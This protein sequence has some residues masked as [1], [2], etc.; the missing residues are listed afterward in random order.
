MM[1]ISVF[2][3]ISVEVLEF[4]AFTTSPLPK[5]RSDK[6]LITIFTSR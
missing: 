3:A 4:V 6:S 5:G 2:V 1:E